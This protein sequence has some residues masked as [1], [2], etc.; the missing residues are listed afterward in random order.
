MGPN[1]IFGDPG[2]PNMI[3]I[4]NGPNSKQ[5]DPGMRMI[6]PAWGIEDDIDR[7]TA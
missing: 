2:N 3:M 4:S 6:I 1:F 7:V 5:P